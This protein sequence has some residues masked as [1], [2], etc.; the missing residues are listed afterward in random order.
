MAA[1]AIS[2]HT[3]STQAEV[4]GPNQSNA[5]AGPDVGANHRIGLVPAVSQVR[6]QVANELGGF[7]TEQAIGGDGNRRE[8][9]TVLPAGL[10]ILSLFLRLMLSQDFGRRFLVRVNDA[11]VNYTVGGALAIIS[12]VLY[13]VHDGVEIICQYTPQQPLLALL[14]LQQ[15]TNRAARKE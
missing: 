10:E 5:E 12:I 11:D 7:S 9:A 2:G 1:D 8:V 4:G 3:G 14:H 6:G 13:L 15:A